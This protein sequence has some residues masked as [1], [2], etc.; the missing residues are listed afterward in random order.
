MSLLLGE[1]VSNYNKIEPECVKT[2]SR[3]FEVMKYWKSLI[4]KSTVPSTLIDACY[5]SVCQMVTVQ[6]MDGGFKNLEV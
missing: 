2:T 6:E 1:H 4:T 3:Y 5:R